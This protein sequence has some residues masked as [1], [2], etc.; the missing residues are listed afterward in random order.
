M[1]LTQRP[2]PKLQRLVRGLIPS[3]SRMAAEYKR[4]S[5][6]QLPS[7]GG[8][9]RRERVFQLFEPVQHQVQLRQGLLMV[10]NHQESAVGGDVVVG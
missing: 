5:V 9:S 3:K 7:E 4:L 6:V 8:A 10:L 2:W 1:L